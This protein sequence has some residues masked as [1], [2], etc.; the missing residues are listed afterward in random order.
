VLLAQWVRSRPLRDHWAG[1]SAAPGT[2]G[3]AAGVGSN[4]V[5]GSTYDRKNPFMAPLLQ[6][7]AL[8]RP[9]VVDFAT[10]IAPGLS[11]VL[12]TGKATEAARRR[13]DRRSDAHVY[14]AV[15]MDAPPT[16]IDRLTMAIEAIGYSDRAMAMP[17]VSDIP[18]DCAVVADLAGCC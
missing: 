16:G 17:A 11:D 9:G 3:K 2:N 14:H 7:K 10:T 8:T 15:V 1:T 18:A 12:V 6:C 4:G 5:A 13:V